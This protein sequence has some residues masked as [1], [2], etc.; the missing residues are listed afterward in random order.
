MEA[1]EELQETPDPETQAPAVL[2]VG[3]GKMGAALISGWRKRELPGNN[4]TVVEPD[5]VQREDLSGHHDVTAVDDPEELPGDYVPGVV[6][7]AV[8]PQLLDEVLPEYQA[9]VEKGAVFLSIAA[10]R[11][12]TELRDKLGGN[13]AVVRAMP[14]TPASIGE[15]MSVLCAGPDVQPGQRA[16]CEALMSSVGGTEWIEDEDMM[17]A[18]TALAGGGPAY[19]FLLIEVMEQVGTEMGLPV[20]VARRLA[21]ETVAGAGSLARRDPSEPAALRQGV[22]SPGGTTAEALDV[23]MTE[24]E[25]L[26]PLMRRAA[27]AAAAR[28]RELAG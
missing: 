23:L 28:S 3:G 7:L 16:L 13:A 21:R 5:Q 24:E 27:E 15:G 14:N 1:N 20:H 11:T 2:L 6:V 8:K 26:K 19:V 10:G 4:I 25:G 17:H 22:A 9:Y 18:V 12:T